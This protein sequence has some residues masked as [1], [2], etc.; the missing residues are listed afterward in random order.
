MGESRSK[1]M[2]EHPRWQVFIVAGVPL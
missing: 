2:R 1:L